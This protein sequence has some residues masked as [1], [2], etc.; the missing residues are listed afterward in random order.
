MDAEIV[1]TGEE[2]RM[3]VLIDSNS[4]HIAQI[5]Q[6][7]GVRVQR[8]MA[9][10]DE[11]ETLAQVLLEIAARADI[12]VVTGGLGPTVDDLTAAAAAKAA[13]V[14]LKSDHAALKS[15]EVFFASRNRPLNPSVR[16]QALLPEGSSCLINP[17]GTAPGFR[18]N[19]G[20]CRFFFLPG[21]P[22]EMRRM[23]Q[24]HVIPQIRELQ[25]ATL[26]FYLSR[27]IS[28]LGLTESATGEQLVDLPKLFPG[29]Q[30]GFRAKFPEIQVKLYAA[31]VHET[32]LRAL[33]DA[34]AHWVSHR[35][36]DT[37]FSIW[38]KSMEEVVGSLLRKANASLAVA[39]CGTSGFVGH[40]LSSVEENHDCFLLSLVAGSNDSIV[41]VLDVSEKIIKTFGAVHEESAKAMAEGVRRLGG[42][43]FGLSVVS[44]YGP[45]DAASDMPGCTVC[46]GLA[47]PRKV[48]CQRFH[49]NYQD[50]FRNQQMVAMTALD[51]L[52]RE[53]SP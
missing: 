33:L 2:I 53:L 31:G 3:G 38:G 44:S 47:A 7:I 15:I 8:H 42:A 4:A 24:D 49:L 1:A 43:T 39:E 32:P 50:R 22:F 19:I 26:H 21:V 28:L 46:I 29:V 16:K 12:A 36:G 27:T 48:S 17:V 52:R 18:L 35:L 37:V 25:G 51:F 14:E 40:L 23:L 45:L 34:A 11:L 41:G 20:R 13:G 6:G 10:G 5:L 9:V 30:L